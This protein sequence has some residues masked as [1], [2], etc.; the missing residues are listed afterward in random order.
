MAAAFPEWPAP[1]AGFASRYASR[2]LYGIICTATC[3][4]AAA[5]GSQPA[6]APRSAGR[7]C[8]GGCRRPARGRV[9]RPCAV[10]R[11]APAGELARGR[12]TRSRRRA[13]RGR[14]AG[15]ASR[16]HHAARAADRVRDVPDVEGGSR[17]V[18]R[19]AAGRGRGVHRIIVQ[20]SY[21]FVHPDSKKNTTRVGVCADARRAFSCSSSRRSNRCCRSRCGSRGR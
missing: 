10:A 13:G 1:P 16:L 15:Q 3:T 17:Q 7:T 20:G 18:V 19:R 12:H 14:R 11:P 6:R 8:E 21:G 9:R 4:A 2:Q 5:R